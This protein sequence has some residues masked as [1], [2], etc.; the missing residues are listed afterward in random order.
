MSGDRTQFGFSAIL[1]CRRCSNTVNKAALSALP[2]SA[3]STCP[4]C[5]GE[6][7]PYEPSENKVGTDPKNAL[8][9]WG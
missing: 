9:G 1:H 3:A 2:E 5:G 8:W 4:S 7:A 6:L